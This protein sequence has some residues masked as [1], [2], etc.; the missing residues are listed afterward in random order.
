MDMQRHG[1]ETI[2]CLETEALEALEGGGYL[3]NGPD[4]A[5]K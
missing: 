1:L 4:P 5:K 3:G 2:L